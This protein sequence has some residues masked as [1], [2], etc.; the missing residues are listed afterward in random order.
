MTPTIIS[1]AIFMVGVSVA[2]IVW[3]QGY[4]VAASARRLTDMMA[5]VGLDPEIATPGD[6]RSKAIIK[7]TRQRCMRCPRE[8]LCDR[9]LAGK[10]TG[11][12]TFCPNAQTFRVLAGASERTG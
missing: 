9:W 7:E 3:L 4:R 8:D 2:S 5:R 10:V 11:D 6:P 12:D 1:V